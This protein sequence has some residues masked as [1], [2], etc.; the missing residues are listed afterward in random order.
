MSIYVNRTLNLKHIQVIGFDMDYTL[1]RYQSK[2]FEEMAFKEMIRKLVNEKNYPEE[3]LGLSFDFSK[4]VR[5]LVF[6]KKRGNLLKLCRYGKVKTCYHGSC[7]LSFSEMQR[8]YKGLVIDLNDRNYA[9]IDT[10]FSV[11]PALL[12]LQLIDLKD[13]NQLTPGSLLQLP[14]YEE[15]YL[16][17]GDALDRSHLDGSLKNKVLKN[18]EHF[19]IQDP[20][21]PQTLEMFK[22]NQKKLVIIT[23]SDFYYTRLLLDHTMN[24]FLKN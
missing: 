23:N 1:V 19:L 9:T 13:K 15:I 24:P 11:S 12:Y 20:F 22:A 7:Q 21:I 5:G 4:I 17:I 6:D 18:P 14:S 2:H 3:I 10:T 8:V 16:D